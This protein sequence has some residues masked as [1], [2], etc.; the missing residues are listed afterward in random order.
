[1]KQFLITL[2]AVAAALMLAVSLQPQ[3]LT[4]MDE[5]TDA[6]QEA[7]YEVTVQQP[8][9][10][11]PLLNG[12]AYRLVLNGDGDMVIDLFVYQNANKAKQEAGYI[13]PDGFGTNTEDAFGFT[14]SVQISWVDAPHFFL[15]KN[16]VVQYIGS[17]DDILAVL[18]KLCGEQFAG[19][20][21]YIST[22]ST[23]IML[24][25]SEYKDDQIV[26]NV[27]N[28][29][30]NPV[31]YGAAYKLYRELDD[32]SWQWLNEDMVF[33][34]IAYFLPAGKQKQVICNWGESLEEGRYR[35]TKNVAVER[36]EPPYDWFDLQAEFSV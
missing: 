29:S 35:I 24:Q 21:Y 9:L 18:E 12:D 5:M 3:D 27:T 8:E 28:G 25:V 7:G 10:H 34:E 17:N 4:T 32:G 1:M 20:P 19:Q 36:E 30:E 33:I 6:L 26:L 23:E 13:E 2:C 15:Y 14:Q 22:D 31:I 11:A 16:V